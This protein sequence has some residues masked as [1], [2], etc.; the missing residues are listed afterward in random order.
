[1]DT[2][3]TYSNIKEISSKRVRTMVKMVICNAVP[4]K[5]LCLLRE[6]SYGLQKDRD[7]SNY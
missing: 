4:K 3:I 1:M 6:N 7:Q 5:G 2:S